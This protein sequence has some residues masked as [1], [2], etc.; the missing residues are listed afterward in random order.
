VVLSPDAVRQLNQLR[1]T[2]RSRLKE[3]IQ[4]SLGE[5]DARIEGKNRFPLRRPSDHAEF[6]FRVGMLR[7]FYKVV[8]LQVRITLI[9]RKEGSQLFVDNKRFRL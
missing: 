3:A 1:A 9:G 2:E 7:V 4:S 6:E 5:D 8:D